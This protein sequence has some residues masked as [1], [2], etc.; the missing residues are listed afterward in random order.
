MADIFFFIYIVF[1]LYVAFVTV[2]W[3]M[4]FCFCFCYRRLKTTRHVSM[5]TINLSKKELN[6]SSAG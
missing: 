3:V 6:T 5:I 1:M 4:K 2:A